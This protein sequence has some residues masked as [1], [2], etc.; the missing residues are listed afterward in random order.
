MDRNSNDDHIGTEWK[1]Q[2]HSKI[3][4]GKTKWTEV[5]DRCV[6]RQWYAHCSQSSRWSYSNT[7]TLAYDA[8]EIKP[9]QKVYRYLCRCCGGTHE[10]CIHENLNVYLYAAKS[11]M[12]H[13]RRNQMRANKCSIYHATVN[14]VTLHTYIICIHRAL[15]VRCDFV[16][17]IFFFF[18]LDSKVS[19]WD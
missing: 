1:T 13:E 5:F 19:F 17:I 8:Y 18:S 6:C 11:S 16:R 15:W 7:V 3:L 14:R 12:I 2:Q 4:I 9:D 10:P